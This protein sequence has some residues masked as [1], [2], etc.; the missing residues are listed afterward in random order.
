MCQ[1]EKNKESKV[2]L[3]FL[4]SCNSLHGGNLFEE[5]D[6]GFS[7]KHTELE[8]PVVIQMEKTYS[9]NEV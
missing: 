4:A 8:M 6:D 9:L 2:A 5:E 7:Y 1:A 3:R